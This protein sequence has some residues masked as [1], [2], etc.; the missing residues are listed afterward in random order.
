MRDVYTHF[1]PIQTRWRDNDLYGHVNNVVFYEYF[2]TA[3][4]RYL[5][6]VGGLDIDGGAAIGVCAESRCTF[7]APV[8]FPVELEAG[9]VVHHLGTS[10]VRYGVGIFDGDQCVASGEFVHVFVDRE[11]RRPTDIPAA[12]RFALEE[13]VRA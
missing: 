1:S 2:D 9:L 11:T 3:I 8:A 13:L 10:S 12:V 5:I 6:D 4:N 7:H